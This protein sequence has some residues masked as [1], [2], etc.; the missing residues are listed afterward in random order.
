MLAVFV[1]LK[2]S[3]SARRQATAA[4]PLLPAAFAFFSGEG[5][6]EGILFRIYEG[7]LEILMDDEEESIN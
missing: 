5:E 6:G 7:M 2:H 4:P 1:V 3:A